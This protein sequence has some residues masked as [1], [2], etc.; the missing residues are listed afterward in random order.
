ML[1]VFDFEAGHVAQAGLKTPYTAKDDP[2][3]LTLLPPSCVAYA[4][5]TE[6]QPR[7]GGETLL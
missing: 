7:P 2:E 5:F 3:L 4:V 6:L 1:C